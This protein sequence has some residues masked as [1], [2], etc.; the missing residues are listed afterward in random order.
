MLRRVVREFEP[1]V[2][3]RG[4]NVLSISEL[5]CCGDGL[6]FEPPRRRKLRKVGANI[7]GYNQT[8]WSNGRKSH[9]IHLRLRHANNHQRFHL[10]EDVAGTL[11]HELAH[12]EHG[13]HNQ[14]FYKLMDDI[15]EEHAMVMAGALSIGG[16]SMPA[17]GGQGQKLGGP[18]RPREQSRLV[19]HA[20][21]KL[22]GDNAFTQWMTPAEA[23][24]VAAEARRR[25]QQLRL[26][27]D[28][29]CRPCTVDMDD[30]DDDTVDAKRPALVTKPGNK[31][32]ASRETAKAT[33]KIKGG[34]E[35]RKPPPSCIDLTIDDDYDNERKVAAA[36]S[37]WPCSACTFL[38][39]SESI[40]CSICETARG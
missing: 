38:N 3:Q 16:Q 2:K 22:G 35:N 27:G 30:Q 11:A 8:T 33:A 36:V 25:Q 17:F 31:K 29:C 23:A 40:H 14:A 15:L 6:D 20:G 1:I 19:Q 7:W 24:V 12:C 26:R 9:T 5:C 28:R 21:Y 34:A 39:R 4:Y 37:T 10:Y 18:E 32:A 13:P